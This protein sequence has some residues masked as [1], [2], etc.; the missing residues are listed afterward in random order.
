M[1]ICTLLFYQRYFLSSDLRHPPGCCRWHQRGPVHRSLRAPNPSTSRIHVIPGRGSVYPRTTV[2]GKV[3]AA[4]ASSSPCP[5][6]SRMAEPPTTNCSRGGHSSTRG[7]R[8]RPRPPS[9]API[10]RGSF[11]PGGEVEALFG[12]KYVSYFNEI[13]GVGISHHPSSEFCSAIQLHIADKFQ[14]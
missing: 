9:R 8:R 6:S 4:I 2:M 5:F 14:F 11:P 12:N 3:A 1:K 7:A 13:V 10:R